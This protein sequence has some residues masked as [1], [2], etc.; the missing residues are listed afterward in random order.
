MTP[1]S[2]RTMRRNAFPSPFLA[3]GRPL[4]FAAAALAV[5]PFATGCERVA[6][7]H[8]ARPARAVA[9]ECEDAPPVCDAEA[10]PTALDRDEPPIGVFDSSPADDRRAPAGLFAATGDGRFVVEREFEPVHFRHDS[11]ILYQPARRKLREYAEWLRAN[12]DV[13]VAIEGH[14]DADGAMEYNYNLGMARSHAV[15]DYL[16][17]EGIAHDRIF[18]ISYGEEIPL[19]EGTDEET[20]AMNRRA[21][22]RAVLAPTESE[23]RVA[24]VAA[25]APPPAPQPPPPAPVARE[26]P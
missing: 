17:G 19:A 23:A 24:S 20:K 10:P 6:D 1:S 16:L 25:S 14:C 22:F 15:R 7:F 11:A 4:R 9:A 13:W 2:E 21:E 12:P 8:G 18:T 26:M 5:L 3:S